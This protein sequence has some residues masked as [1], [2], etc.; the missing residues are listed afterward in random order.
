MAI[1]GMMTAKRPTSMQNASSRFQNGVAAPRPAKALS[2]LLAAE[3][4]A[5]STSLCRAVQGWHP[6]RPASVIIASAVPSNTSVG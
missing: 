6:A 2:L 4:T 1:T 5:Y 3:V